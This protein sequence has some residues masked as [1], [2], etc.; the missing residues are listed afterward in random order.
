MKTTIFEPLQMNNTLV[1]DV[2]TPTIANR[3]VGYNERG[4]LDDYEILTT[5]DGGMFS[6]IDDLHL[7]DQALYSEKL[8]ARATLEE[9]FTR[10]KLNNGVLTGYGFGWGVSEKQGRKVVQH[11]GGLSGYRAF[12]RRKLYNNSAY[13]ILTNHGGKSN[14]G[15]IIGALDEILEGK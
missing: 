5:G 2:A 10:A 3:A 8:I 7:W 15:V 9:A 12:I 1:Y 11:S 4:K 13:I 14:I 6:T